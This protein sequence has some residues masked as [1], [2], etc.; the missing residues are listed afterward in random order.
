MTQPPLPPTWHP[1]PILEAAAAQLPADARGDESTGLD[2]V[3]PLD[4][5][6]ARAGAQ[7]RKGI[8]DAVGG[9]PRADRE[10]A[11]LAA[12]RVIG[13]AY[14]AGL[15]AQEFARATGD[16]D[17]ASRMLAEGSAARLSPRQ[18]AIVDFAGRLSATPPVAGRDD[19][20]ALQTAGLSSQ[21]IMDLVNVAALT[22]ASSRLALALGTTG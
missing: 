1:D 14:T 16:S 10:L 15:H 21:E 4:P 6:G 22:A 18:R 17:T 8:L 13:C 2:L 9:L 3:L 19:I 11:A 20:S 7:L 5:L 12:A